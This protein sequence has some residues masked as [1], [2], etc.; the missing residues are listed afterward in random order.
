MAKA[1]GLES[2]FLSPWSSDFTRLKALFF[3]CNWATEAPQPC[4]PQSLVEA[5]PQIAKGT[6]EPFNPLMAYQIQKG[7]LA[8]DRACGT[9]LVEQETT[10]F[11]L[12]SWRQQ[13]RLDLPFQWA[14]RQSFLTPQDL[15]FKGL[16]YD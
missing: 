5:K 12:G 6:G 7:C 10:V 8:L 16:L 11:V 1:V 9:E 14:E 2:T 4:P 15:L 3:P 13:A